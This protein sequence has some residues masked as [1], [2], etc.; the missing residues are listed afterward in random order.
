MRP[1]RMRSH[2]AGRDRQR[3]TAKRPA[4]FPILRALRVP[5]AG[6][7]TLNECGAA[8]GRE[9][10]VD[11]CSVRRRQPVDGFGDPILNASGALFPDGP[12]QPSTVVQ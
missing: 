7:D 3:V 12:R 6:Q 5:P 10:T 2:V 8:H 1:V 4:V 11:G 9:Q